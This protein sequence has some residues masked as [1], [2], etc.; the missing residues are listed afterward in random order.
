MTPGTAPDTDPDPDAGAVR[1]VLAAIDR[2]SR[3]RLL[4]ALARRYGDLDLAEDALQEALSRALIA[5]PRTGIPRTPEA[6]LMTAAK[7]AAVDLLR[8][9]QALARRAGSLAAQLDRE[10]S[11]EHLRD[12]AAP[13]DASSADEVPDD[14][15]ALFFAC[16][17]PALRI[18]DRIA[19]T[20]RFVAGLTT[21]EIA[22][23]LLI[24]T[25]TLQARITRAKVRI[26]KLGIS[27]EMPGGALLAER[28][29][30]VR[31]IVYL[32]YTAGFARATGES[33]VRDDLTA[34][35]IRLAR[36]LL[37]RQPDSAENLGLLGLLLL[38]EARRPAR[39]DATGRPVPLAEQ[40]RG[41]WDP[42]L[43]AA[44]ISLAERAAAMPDAGSYTVQCA[45]AAVHAEAGSFPATDWRQIAVLYRLLESHE[46]GPVVRLGRAVA[47]GRAY[48]PE[49]GIRL[50]D[51]LGADP[52]LDRSRDYHIA[53]AVTLEELGDRAGAATAYR[54]ALELDGNEAEE[55]LLLSALA[56]VQPPRGPRR[57]P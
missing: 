31:R 41:L 19:L 49:R 12:P 14:R 35:A 22:H 55:E 20:L 26:R 36:L 6:W 10:P 48:G 13:V 34:E 9:E 56:A 24:P 43:L 8:R 50:L 21:A 39:T 2:E 7:H 40:D 18:E 17:H 44:G 47:L 51:E 30:G 3:A 25:A 23:A 46:P 45:I 52:R 5:W 42:E 37:A 53:R 4:A 16:S 33:H 1:P 28:I 57:R 15:L 29:H 38:A 54:R 11:P 32:L 27:F